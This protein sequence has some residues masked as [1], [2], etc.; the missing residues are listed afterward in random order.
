MT[1][2]PDLRDRLRHVGTLPDEDLDVGE[3]ALLAAAA[4]RPGLSLEPYLRHLDGLAAEVA[5]HAH[6]RAGEA[7]LG[8]RAEALRQILG[9]RYG[10]LGDEDA[11]DDPYAWDLPGV[12]D[13]RRGLP[14]ALGILYLSVAWRLGWSLQGLDFPVRLLVRLEY[15]GRRVIL[16]PADGGRE[17]T[18]QDLRDFYKAAAGNEAELR[19][20]DWRPLASREVLLRLQNR[21]RADLI[22]AGRF[23]EALAAVEAMQRIVPDATPLWREAGYLHARLDNLPAAVA[24]LD[25]YL[26]RC[27]QDAGRDQ[28]ATLLRDLRLKLIG[29]E[30]TKP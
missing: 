17:R 5:A 26:A 12:I 4:S 8:L 2:S 29:R 20:Q 3:A 22:R 24:A 19:P 11:P 16:D 1:P 21:L 10:Y 28:A 6:R 27:G 25:D 30:G 7:G 23:R 9:R 15:G 18:V 13:R 14:A